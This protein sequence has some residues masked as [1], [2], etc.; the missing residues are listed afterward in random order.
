[1]HIQ[2]G[3][4]DDLSF[5]LRT[6]IKVNFYLNIYTFTLIRRG[7]LKLYKIETDVY[8]CKYIFGKYKLVGTF[9]LKYNIK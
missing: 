6:Y 2:S 3:F 4:Q 5:F 9:K 8:I 1:M 7:I